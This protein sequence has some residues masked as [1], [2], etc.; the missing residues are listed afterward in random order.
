MLLQVASNKAYHLLE[1]VSCQLLVPKW[2]NCACTI[3]GPGVSGR[4]LRYIDCKQH[5]ATLTASNTCAPRVYLNF[6]KHQAISTFHL[7]TC[8]HCMSGA[9]MAPWHS[10]TVQSCYTAVG[11]P[12]A[13]PSSTPH[14]QQYSTQPA[15][16]GSTPTLSIHM[17]QL[18]PPLQTV[19]VEGCTLGGTN[20]KTAQTSVNFFDMLASMCLPLVAGG[21]VVHVGSHCLDLIIIQGT[22]PGCQEQQQDKGAATAAAAALHRTATWWQRGSRELVSNQAFISVH[23]AQVMHSSQ[24]RS[25]PHTKQEAKALLLQCACCPSKRFTVCLNQPLADLSHC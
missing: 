13:T 20:H 15:P 18:W 22:L 6:H 19:S 7:H 3:L 5:C 23:C 16:S 2:G 11:K 8:Q 1:S 25:E 9:N 12:H 14:T 4:P 24:Q 21:L 17:G 10:V